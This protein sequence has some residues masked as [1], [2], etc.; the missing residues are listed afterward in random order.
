MEGV[1]GST[2]QAPPTTQIPWTTL[3]IVATPNNMVLLVRLVKS[4][5][6]MG[7]ELYMGEHYDE[8]V[9]R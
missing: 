6:E 2:T 5:G 8:I 4:M 1:V 7:C 9:G 3:G